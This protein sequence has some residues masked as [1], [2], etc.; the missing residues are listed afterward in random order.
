MGGPLSG[1]RSDEGIL[2]QE[3]T[4]LQGESPAGL[5]ARHDAC[6]LGEA[7]RLGSQALRIDAPAVV[8]APATQPSGS[9][10]GVQDGKLRAR[11]TAQDAGYLVGTDA[12][13]HG[14]ADAREAA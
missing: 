7:P 13:D 12:G 14:H 9:I 1:V 3:W 6:D 2:G 8:G 5:L 4:E 10:G 11:P